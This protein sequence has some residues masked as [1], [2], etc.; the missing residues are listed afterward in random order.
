MGARRGPPLASRRRRESPAAELAGI[1]QFHEEREEPLVLVRPRGTEARD[2][3]RPLPAIALEARVQHRTPVGGDVLGLDTAEARTAE[4]GAIAV[5][6]LERHR[7]HPALEPEALSVSQ[8]RMR[9]PVREGETA[10]GDEH[11]VALAEHGRLVRDV[12]QPFLAET[13]V[14]RMAPERER[15]RVTAD[16]RD[17]RRQP[18]VPRQ[19]RGARH[20][21]PVNLDPDDPAATA[22]GEES[23]GAP[24][25]GAD[26]EHARRGVH[27]RAARQDVDGADPAV[28]VL[29]EVEEVVGGEAAGGTTGRGRADVCL[30]DRMPVV[31]VDGSGSLP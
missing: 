3:V 21:R 24:E 28:V 4:Q 31:E 22:A 27:A 29:V 5:E 13:D 2:D 7:G 23:R 10:T 14:E 19:T 8:T 25:P 9:D 20:P 30:V 16:H 18:D 15:A 6:G 1:D 11:A 26:V 17:P 12:E